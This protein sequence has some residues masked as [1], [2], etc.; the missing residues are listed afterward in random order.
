LQGCRKK[1]KRR[2][3]RN[4]LTSKEKWPLKSKKLKKSQNVRG[5]FKRRKSKQNKTVPI[6]AKSRR[7]PGMTSKW[8]KTKRM[9]MLGSWTMHPST[10]S[11]ASFLKLL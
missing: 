1:R 11:L 10:T 6:L 5:M 4:V 3:K 7:Q 8:R 2:R 9:K